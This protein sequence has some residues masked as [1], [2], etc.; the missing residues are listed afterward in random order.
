MREIGDG[1]WRR[2]AFVPFRSFVAIEA[3]CALVE[4]EVDA[5]GG[6]TAKRERERARETDPKT[7]D[8]CLFFATR[9]ERK[10]CRC[11]KVWM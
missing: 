5:R 9:A 3:R 6:G 8:G 11:R 10:R 2:D 1:W 4:T 7:T